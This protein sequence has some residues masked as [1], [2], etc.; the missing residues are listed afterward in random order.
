MPHRWLPADWQHPTRVDVITGYHL[1]PIHPDDTEL[2]MPAVTGSRSRLWQIYGAAWGWPPE[3]MTFEQ[4]RADLQHHWDEMQAQEAFNYALFN[5]EETEL[6]GCVYLDPPERAGADA[7]ISWWVR[8][9]Y[10]GSLVEAALDQFVPSWVAREWPLEAPRYIG[11]D[12]SWSDWL[13]LPQD[14]G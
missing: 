12:I 6:I 4:D 13:A 14:P 11:R 5:A 10:V 8:D 3:T 2:D 9:E 7:D 1:R